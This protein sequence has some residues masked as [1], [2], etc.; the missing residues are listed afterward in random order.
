LFGYKVSRPRLLG[1]HT[2]RHLTGIYYCD[3]VSGEIS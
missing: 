3:L 2:L 1:E